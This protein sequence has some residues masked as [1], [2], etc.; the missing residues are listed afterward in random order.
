MYAPY[1]FDGPARPTARTAAFTKEDGFLIDI[2]RQNNLRWRILSYCV[3]GTFGLLSPNYLHASAA[4]ANW[5][6]NHIEIGGK[7]ENSAGAVSESA[8]DIAHIRTVTKISVSE[9][10][11][12]FGVSRQAVHEWIKGGALS[13]R[14]AQRL[15]ELARATDVFLE[16]EIEVSPQVFRR[17]ISGGTSILDAIRDDGNVVDLART[18]AATLARE[19]QQHQRLAAR[20]AGRSATSGT[21]IEFGSPH[22]NEDA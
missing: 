7:N 15:S 16:A 4:T 12:V 14:N 22:L 13:P 17:K 8:R 20:L 10:S 11:R 18:L 21:S 1:Q 2:A 3:A 5:D 6:I 19:S 9:L